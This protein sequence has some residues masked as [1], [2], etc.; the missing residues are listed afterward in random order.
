MFRKCFFWLLSICSYSVSAQ[1]DLSNVFPPA[2]DASSLGKFAEFPVGYYTGLP[3]I[4]VPIYVLKNGPIAVDVSLSYHASGIHVE[5][6]ASRVGLGW[7]L[8]AGGVISRS[9]VGLPDDTN[10]PGR[11]GFLDYSDN[12]PYSIENFP[13]Q[14]PS[15][16][17]SL[18]QQYQSGCVDPESDSYFFNVGGVSGK[19]SFAWDKSI[20]IASDKKVVI[21]PTIVSNVITKWTLT[22]DDGTKF[23]FEAL[24]STTQENTGEQN[25]LTC[26]GDAITYT[27][28]W[29]LTKIVSAN[30]TH[31]VNFVY[32]DYTINHGFAE[33]ESFSHKLTYNNPIWAQC[34][35]TLDPAIVVSFST[36]QTAGKRL[37]EI[38]SS[39]GFQVLMTPTPQPR[40][41]VTGTNNYAVDKI[42]VKY[43]GEL[44]N[45]HKFVY[46]YSNGSRL[47]L[48]SV[49]ELGN[50]SSYLKPAHSFVYNA[51][52]LPA[53]TSKQQDY[54]GYYN[55]NAATHLVP[56]LAVL[57]SGTGEYLYFSGADR[58]PDSVKMR[59]GVLEKITY[60]TGGSTT[61]KYEPHDYSFVQ[62]DDVEN[63]QVPILKDTTIVVTREGNNTQ[64]WTNQTLVVTYKT[65]VNIVA[66][67]SPPP[68]LGDIQTW[69]YPKVRI[70]D[71]GSVIKYERTYQQG[72]HN[73]AVLLEPGTYTIGAYAYATN[74]SAKDMAS[75]RIF[76]KKPATGHI[77][78]KRFIGGGLRIKRMTHYDG[79][80][81]A[82][83]ITEHFEYNLVSD[84]TK[85]SGVLMGEIDRHDDAEN[86]FD[87][88]GRL[89]MFVHEYVTLG[90]NS[91]VPC[92]YLNRFSVNRS[93]VG[94]TSG[95]HIGYRNVTVYKN[96]IS[97]GKSVFVYDSPY[98]HTDGILNDLP[99][100]PS[101]SAEHRRGLLRKKSDH[102]FN[103]TS[104]DLVQEEITNY[105]YNVQAVTYFKAAPYIT[106]VNQDID[107]KYSLYQSNFGYS[108]PLS[109]E[110]RVYPGPLS[111]TT[112][113]VYSQ[114]DKQ[115][116]KTTTVASDGSTVETEF[117]HPLDF[118]SLGNSAVDSLLQ[119]NIFGAP[120][121]QEK[122]INT[123]LVEG[124]A[125]QYK[126]FNG[127]LLPFKTFTYEQ[128]V[129]GTH[130]SETVLSSK[131]YKSEILFQAYDLDGNLLRHVGRDGLTETFIWGYD[132]SLPI[133]KVTNATDKLVF[134][135]S[136][137]D[138]TT[139]IS[140]D[141]KTG[142]KSKTN[143]F[144]KSL[145]QLIG[146]AYKLTY[147][148]KQGAQWVL[149]KEDVNVTGSTYSI[150]LTGQVDE[151][152][153]HPSNS[154]MSTYAYNPGVGVTSVTDPNNVTS[155]YFYDDFNRLK[156]IKDDKGKV[157]KT[158]QYHYKS[159]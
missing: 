120:L 23:F 4:N 73:T 44:L 134:H 64:T 41:D 60:P 138:E 22:T 36:M 61:F 45:E 48:K 103:G 42:Q 74:G 13:I 85:S 127:L 91:P 70:T 38:N 17:L 16:R 135:T 96:D 107:Y 55:S 82:N 153:F 159:E 1:V 52:Q 129:G 121:L 69:M 105:S 20:V 104:F 83:N 139:N 54:W 63:L 11:V 141:A 78:K 156:A 113:F 14:S 122:K 125:T 56:S 118:S 84:I 137:E 97:K 152:R 5:E 93:S 115:L 40:T 26:N 89:P 112:S 27:S 67:F 151:V 98:E 10:A 158:F 109:T 145:N 117:K 130:V 53:R 147:W 25:Q 35:G 24:E 12:L 72:Y 119:K 140:T 110:L 3:Q 65:V 31:E 116:K 71:S 148:Q 62:N 34:P 146:G 77:I 49:Q 88:A 58:E 128:P 102:L 18:L 75:I 50:Q 87:L 144:S 33:S 39:N 68:L 95:N 15:A 51:T 106:P 92:K 132:S 150:S 111:S 133:A 90:A 155:Y 143:G 59:A 7:A 2:P 149:I 154:L 123:A 8:N 131:N 46:D 37:T 47:T 80:N 136:F 126:S 86:S 57:Y 81:V 101:A 114:T 99:Y 21:V 76:W 108:T 124:Q 6:I 30:G 94:S 9:V 19:F 100:P 28:S 66:E 29:Y 157:L 43:N 142:R 32:T 79:V